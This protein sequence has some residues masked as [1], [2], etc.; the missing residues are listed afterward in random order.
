M[1][2][3]VDPDNFHVRTVVQ[4]RADDPTWYDPTPAVFT[5]NQSTIGLMTGITN[6][7]TWQSFPIFQ[8]RGSASTWIITSLLDG[9]KIH[10]LTPIPTNV[11]YVLDLSYGK[12]T[13]VNDLGNNII[14]HITNDS[15]LAT[16]SI[17]VGTNIIRISGSGFDANTLITMTYNYR[18]TGI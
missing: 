16:W 1:S 13:Y 12:K 6:T 7:G 10:S 8:L 4:L 9:K 3:D 15:S 5:W 18:F 11:T 2:F 17:P 14:Q